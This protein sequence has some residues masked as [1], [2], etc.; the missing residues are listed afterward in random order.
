MSQA[1]RP[2]SAGLPSTMVTGA[3]RRDPRSTRR[4]HRGYDVG[5]PVEH[6]GPAPAGSRVAR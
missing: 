4:G 6:Q 3:A 2:T 1:P 5:V